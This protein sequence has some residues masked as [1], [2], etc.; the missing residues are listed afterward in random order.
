MS[1]LAPCRCDPFDWIIGTERYRLLREDRQ[2]RQR[3][4][5]AFMSV[6]IWSEWCSLCLRVY[7]KLTESLWVRIKERA[8]KGD[9]ILRVCY[10]PTD[11]DWVRPSISRQ[12][13][14]FT[15]PGPHGGL[16]SPSYWLEG[17]HRR[18]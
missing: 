15:S 12:E 3:K 10:R 18:I 13:H 6:A 1:I 4:D 8:D 14:T 5:V 17:L 7:E 2:G 9:I 16:Q 11:Q